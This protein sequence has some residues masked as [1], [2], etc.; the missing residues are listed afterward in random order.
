MNHNKQNL[1]KVWQNLNTLIGKDNHLLY[2]DHLNIHNLEVHDDTIIANSVNKSFVGVGPDL[3]AKFPTHTNDHLRYLHSDN[4][5]SENIFLEPTTDNEICTAFQNISSPAGGWDNFTKM[6]LPSIFPSILPCLTNII[7][8]S[9]YSGTVPSELKIAKVIPLFKANDP[10]TLTNYRPISILPLISKILEKLVH[11]RLIKFLNK[12]KIL[13]TQQ[14]GFRA[15]HST[16]SALTLLD[17]QIS[18]A[19]DKKQL[20]LGICLDFSKAF[21]TVNFQ[22]LFDKL[23]HYGI[24]GI[25][26]KWIKKTIYLT[27][28]NSSYTKI[29]SRIG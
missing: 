9:F 20:T 4:Y 11:K 7:N 5:N 21:D 25:P 14:F 26:L 1:R 15:N 22:I 23:Y 16:D 27:V 2:P 19:F 13:H 6:I 3:A 28:N 29:P 24:R 10:Y 17:F 12:F 18:Q 8:M